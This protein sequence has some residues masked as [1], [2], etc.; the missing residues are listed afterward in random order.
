MG[1]RHDLDELDNAQK[2]VSSVRNGLVLPLDEEE[3]SI[4]ALADAAQ[5]NEANKVA[6]LLVDD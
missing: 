6:E 3:G 5:S 4:S 1:K 2:S